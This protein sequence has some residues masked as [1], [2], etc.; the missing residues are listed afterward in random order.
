MAENLL[1]KESCA[2]FSRL[3]GAKITMPGGGA[4]SALVGALGAALCEMAANFTIGNRRYA[5]VEPE[6][7]DIAARAE[8]LRVRLLE[9]AD[10]D[11]KAFPEL[12]AAWKLPKDYPGR[13][14]IFARVTL[15]A[16]KAPAEMVRRCCDALD[17]LD[18]AMEKGNIMLISDVGC[19]VSLCEA[20]MTSAAMN[21]YVNTGSLK[22]CQEARDLE[23]E[24]DS[25]MAEYMQKADDISGK[26]TLIVRR[27]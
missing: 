12:S 8:K 6:M 19:G 26:I 21:V 9:L 27:V 7:K 16:C 3:V 10:E 22:D 20:A 5:D 24:I 1:M 14:E 2:E 13:K 18:T 15:N 4:V 17:L 25:L 23:S 11:A